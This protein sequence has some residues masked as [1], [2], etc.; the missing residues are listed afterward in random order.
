M[1]FKTS[2]S[3]FSLKRFIILAVWLKTFRPSDPGPA[4]VSNWTWYLFTF[5]DSFWLE[6]CFCGVTQ[7]AVLCVFVCIV[8][9]VSVASLSPPA[10]CTCQ[11]SAQN[12]KQCY[13]NDRFFSRSSPSSDRQSW[14]LCVQHVSSFMFSL[15]LLF[16][17]PLLSASWPPP[18]R[19]WSSE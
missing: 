10:V 13:C 5:Q 15:L 16:Q 11:T 8:H 4:Q 6:R 7:G 1:K 3:H 9:S 17:S 12:F 18:R 14:P 19:H 2:S